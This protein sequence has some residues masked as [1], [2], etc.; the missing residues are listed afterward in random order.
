MDTSNAL[1][2]KA[3]TAVTDRPIGILQDNPKGATG[4]PVAATVAFAGVSKAIAG[5][6]GWTR[7]DRLGVTAAGALITLSEAIATNNNCYIVAVALDSASAA[8]MNFLREFRRLS[9]L[10]VASRGEAETI[11]K[12]ALHTE[13]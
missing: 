9:G 4:V 10:P 12:A 7:G 5:S 3:M 8:D 13:P 11:R 1:T 6:G 2:V